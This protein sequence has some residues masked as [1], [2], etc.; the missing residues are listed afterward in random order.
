MDVLCMRVLV[1]EAIIF[2]MYYLKNIG[3]VVMIKKLN[4]HRITSR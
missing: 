4:A 1:Q 3:T 2:L